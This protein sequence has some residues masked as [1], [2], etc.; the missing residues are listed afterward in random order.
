M[1]KIHSLIFLLAFLAAC[2][3]KVA[4]ASSK[5]AIPPP[6]ASP[7]LNPGDWGAS[8]K[9]IYEAKCGRCH[10]LP[11]PASYSYRRWSY[12]MD[13][14]APKAKLNDSEKTMVLTY[15]QDNAKQE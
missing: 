6:P 9:M 11:K 2:T 8:G 5:V 12:I 15:V 14:M 3:K 7:L 13:E 4:P 1:K 10:D